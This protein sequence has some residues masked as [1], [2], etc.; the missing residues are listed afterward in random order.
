MQEL[1]GCLHEKMLRLY[2]TLHPKK[3]KLDHALK[4]NVQCVNGM[5][6]ES[7]THP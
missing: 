4:N 7:M 1:V 6:Q 5:A 3:N 2:Q